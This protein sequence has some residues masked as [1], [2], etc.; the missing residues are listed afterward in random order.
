MIRVVAHQCGQVESGG[1]AGLAL[2]EQIAEAGVGVFRRAEAGELA[3]GPEA[4]AVH[5]GVNA[6]RVRRNAG[7]AQ[8]ARGVPAGEIRFGIKASNGMA[9]SGG[10][11]VIPLGTFLQSGL[12]RVLLPGEFLGGGRAVRRGGFRRSEGLRGSFGLIGHSRF[13]PME[14]KQASGTRPVVML[15]ERWGRGKG[16]SWKVTADS[17]INDEQVSR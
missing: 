1:E 9:G 3:H 11:V 16:G 7:E 15:C 5:G 8:G 14:R 2:R 4:R 6:A 12:E 10:E 17:E 13:S